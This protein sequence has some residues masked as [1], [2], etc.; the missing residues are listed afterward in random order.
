[1]K[2]QDIFFLVILA[3]LI[4]MRNPRWAT[5]VGVLLLVMSIPLFSFW[6]FFTAERLVWYAA[7][8][9]LVAVLMAGINLKKER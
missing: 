6:I 7:A 1:M 9:F 5:I 2:I 8:C 3:F 4:F